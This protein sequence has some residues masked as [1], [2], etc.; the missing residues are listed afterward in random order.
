[1]PS[2]L[3]NKVRQAGKTGAC[4]KAGEEAAVRQG[5]MGV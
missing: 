1:L 2:N 3:A 4:V 5:G